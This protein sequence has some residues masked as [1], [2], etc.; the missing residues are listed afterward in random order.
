MVLPWATFLVP[1]GNNIVACNFALFAAMT[2]KPDKVPVEAYGA[3]CLRQQNK[4]NVKKLVHQTLVAPH[5]AYDSS[6]MEK[7]S[8]LSREIYL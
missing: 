1:N 2:S 8:R 7:P 4:L 5:S 6:V 3:S